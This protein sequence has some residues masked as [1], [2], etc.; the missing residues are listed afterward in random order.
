MT[1]HFDDDDPD[2]SDPEIALLL[3][4]IEASIISA[5]S[6]EAPDKPLGAHE[7]RDSVQPEAKPAASDVVG[8]FAF[9]LSLGAILPTGVIL[10]A[11]AVQLFSGES[12][13]YAGSFVAAAG[14]GALCA[15]LFIKGH[16]SVLI[17]EFKHSLVSNIVGNKR[18]GMKIGRDSGYFEY[19]Y[20]KETKHFNAFIS[21]A[22]YIVPVFT[23][24]AALLAFATARHQHIAAVLLVGF[25]Y[26]IDLV[27]NIRDISPVQTDLSLIRGGYRIGVLYVVAWNVLIFGFLT[28]WILGGISGW[29]HILESLSIFF[30][31]VHQWYSHIPTSEG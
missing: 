20:S 15:H 23:F 13:K 17:H 26:G 24:V 2:V 30:V 12:S 5:E 28:A 7:P 21:L 1:R 18:K 14:A 3:K 4:E 27:L 31:K 11:L 29:M 19:A 10:L 9:F 8:G 25:G 22:P 6:K 16:I